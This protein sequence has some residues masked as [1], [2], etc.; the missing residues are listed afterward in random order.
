MAFPLCTLLII[1]IPIINSGLIYSSPDWKMHWTEKG[2]LFIT[3]LITLNL[4]AG[5][6]LW[7]RTLKGIVV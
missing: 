5:L 3:V 2:R 1:Y 6:A 4:E 7:G